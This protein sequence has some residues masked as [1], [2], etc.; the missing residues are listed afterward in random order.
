MLPLNGVVWVSIL[1]SSRKKK[2]KNL[3]GVFTLTL[4][5]SLRL[6]LHYAMSVVCLQGT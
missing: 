3:M 4:S 6:S 5:M 2:V 1:L